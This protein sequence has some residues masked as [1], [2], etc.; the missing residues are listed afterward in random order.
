MKISAI[1][2]EYNPFHNGHATMLKKMKDNGSTH[3]IAVM[4]GNFTQRAEPA[5]FDKYTRTKAALVSGVDLVIELPVSFACSGAER[6]AFG[7]VSIVNSLGCVNELS[8]G[9]ECGNIE[10]L[11]SAA[12]AIC[13]D[14]VSVFIKKYLSGGLTFAAARQRAVEK[15]YGVDI[16]DVL[17]YPN[18]ILAVEYIK[19]LKKFES[20]IT[21]NT[22]SR[23]AAFHDSDITSDK[24]ASASYIR[25][26]FEDKK[27]YY[28]FIPENVVKIYSSSENLPYHS[29]R[30]AA[31]ENMM[32]YRL[33]MMNKDEIEEL[34]EIGEGLHNRFYN[35]VRIG[36]SISEI[37]NYVK[38]KRYTMSRIRRCMMYA[39]LGFKKTN[40]PKSPL[41][42][43]VLGFNDRGK[44]ILRNMKETSKLPIIMK[45]SDV[46]KLSEQ[47]K[48]MFDTESRCDDIFA[49]SSEKKQP[50]GKNYVSNLIII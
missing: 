39:L 21:P 43:R 22:I 32:L 49:L 30:M 41:Y 34:P 9:S 40:L 12:D 3:I 18:N 28:E 15:L 45:Y 42:I 46:S 10:I 38:T 50:C 25:K 26:L 19:A 7:G 27:N 37:A 1:I 11:K 29:G 44:D 14:E 47:V 48:E 23:I 16:A 2:C 8:F 33:R 20:H 31:L 24:I 6:F 17:S 13:S 35:A 5:I 36:T 4:G